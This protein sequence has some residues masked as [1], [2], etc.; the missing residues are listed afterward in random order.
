MV[1]K[2]F[3]D[4]VDAAVVPRVAFQK[5]AYCKVCAAPG[6]KTL[7]GLN[8]V[9]RASGKE[10]AMLANPRADQELID[11]DEADEKLAHRLNKVLQWWSRERRRS[12]ES[13]FAAAARAITT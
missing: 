1:S 9:I 12:P 5:P 13:A 7:D 4:R 11:T 10:S 8:G 6:A 2:L 3:R